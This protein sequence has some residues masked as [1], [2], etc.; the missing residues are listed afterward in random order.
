MSTP[1]RQKILYNLRKEQGI[2]VRC[3]K[4]ESVANKT[5]CISCSEK[6]SALKKENKKYFAKLGLCTICGKN[7]AEPKKKA[8]YECLGREQDRYYEQKASG[9]YN[10]QKANTEIKRKITEER[11]SKGMCYR[12]GKRKADRL[13]EMCKAKAKR[14]RDRNKSNL[15]RSEWVSY[16]FCYCCGKNKL[17]KDYKVCEPCYNVRLS[18]I[19]KMLAGM[20]METNYF[21]K[22]NDTYFQSRS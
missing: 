14:Y 8:C 10:K 9:T 17:Y 1:E 21:R 7:E 13:C 19:P 12:C 6:L 20:N 16:G 15:D 4:N 3:G 11:R 5:M 22:L 2:C 18:T